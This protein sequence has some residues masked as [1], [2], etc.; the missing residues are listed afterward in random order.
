MFAMFMLVS[1]HQK[2]G[3]AA[4]KKPRCSRNGKGSHWKQTGNTAFL[5]VL[6][7]DM[8]VSSICFIK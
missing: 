3:L 2:R 7:L 1:D 8:S 5:M 6:P 4:K